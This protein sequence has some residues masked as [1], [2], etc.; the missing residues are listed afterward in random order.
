MCYSY[1]LTCLL[2]LSFLQPQSSYIRASLFPLSTGFFQNFFFFFF[3][4]LWRS[5]GLSSAPGSVVRMTMTIMCYVSLAAS[6]R[7]LRKHLHKSCFLCLHVWAHQ[8]RALSIQNVQY[9][10][11][12]T[13]EKLRGLAQFFHRGL[14]QKGNSFKELIFM[15]YGRVLVLVQE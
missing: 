8:A 12:E 10:C 15:S 14:I 4:A 1:C 11:C 13:G 2:N 3:L 7:W 5:P 6:V 9:L